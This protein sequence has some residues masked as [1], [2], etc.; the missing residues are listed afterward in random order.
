MK[1][2]LYEFLGVEPEATP[3]EIK[4]VAQALARKFHPAKYP[5]NA[6]VAAHFNKI[7]QVYNILAN[8]QKRAAYDIALAKQRAAEGSV[9]TAS[10]QKKKAVTTKQNRNASIPNTPGLKKKPVAT[11]ATLT[12][13]RT[14]Q[15]VLVSS[16]QPQKVVNTK[17]NTMVGKEKPTTSTSTLAKQRATAQVAPRSSSSP[18]KRKSSQKPI[19]ANEKNATTLALQ[20]KRVALA[21][22]RAAQAAQRSSPSSTVMQSVESVSQEPIGTDENVANNEQV[23]KKRGYQTKRL[24]LGLLFAGLLAGGS[25]YFWLINPSLLKTWIN[26]IAFLQDNLFY[27]ESSLPVIFGFSVL[28]LLYSVFRVFRIIT[29]TRAQKATDLEQP[30]SIPQKTPNPEKTP[31]PEQ[32]QSKPEKT[33][34]PEPKRSKPEKTPKL[35]QNKPVPALNIVY[36]SKIAWFSYLLAGLLLGLPTYVWYIDPMLLVVIEVKFKFLPNYLPYIE[37]SLPIMFWLGFLILLYALFQ[38]FPK[39]V[40]KTHIQ[41]PDAMAT[42]DAE[43]EQASSHPAQPLSEKILYRADIHGFRSLKALVIMAIPIYL[44]WFDPE[45][46][47]TYLEKMNFWTQHFIYVERGLLIMLGIM[48]LRFLH[49]VFQQFT[50]TLMITSQRIIARYGLI[51]RKQIEIAFDKFEHIEINQSIVGKILSFG[52]IKIR[53]TKGRGVGG[54]KINVG[55][56][57]SPR[58]F[59]KRLIRVMKNNAYHQI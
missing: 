6:K 30:A 18:Q 20:K 49:I 53:G 29:K 43:S 17:K 21:K 32:R 58:Q 40:A 23:A 4:V 2:T 16:S 48:V 24:W 19:S 56:V 31:E 44:L 15:S 54:L 7:K 39:P 1:K 51:F 10:P 35:E 14:T 34:K 33:P 26:N 38:L 52:T 55:Y 8:P 36:H 9:P 12:K 5:G 46:L 11:K 22:Q 45:L 3:E 57:A 27:I 28:V 13:Q 25:A 50:T 59:E 41:Q 47:K 37:R 42:T